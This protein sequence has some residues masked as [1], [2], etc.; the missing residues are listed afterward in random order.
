MSLENLDGMSAG[1]RAMEQMLDRH[2]MLEEIVSRSYQGFIEQQERAANFAAKPT[3]IERMEDDM[4]RFNAL[5]ESPLKN[6]L[7]ER[8]FVDQIV[9]ER[10][11]LTNRFHNLYENPIA[12]II[13]ANE[14][15]ERLWRSPLEDYLRSV[16]RDDSVR[17]N[18][19]DVATSLL[20]D[21]MDD[22]R[23]EDFAS[24]LGSVR[25]EDDHDFSTWTADAFADERLEIFEEIKGGEIQD[26]RRDDQVNWL[27]EKWRQSKDR[28]FVRELLLIECATVVGGDYINDE[29]D[30]SYTSSFGMFLCLMT[31]YLAGKM[32][33]KSS[34]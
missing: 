6:M 29:Y 3:F 5:T 12:A 15:M 23:R 24:F 8:K 25:A 33:A 17:F 10:Q 30:I 22:T 28:G 4:R 11:L 27:V 2:K 18:V 14:K 32:A 9:S 1:M 19:A 20:A 31:K 7:A 34:T 21:T 16:P 13:E 26:F